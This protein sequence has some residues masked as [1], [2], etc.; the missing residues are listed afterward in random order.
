MRLSKQGDGRW[1]GEVPGL[2]EVAAYGAH[3]REALRLT[4]QLARRVCSERFE[5]GETVPED[6]RFLLVD[7]RIAFLCGLTK[8]GRRSCRKV[9]PPAPH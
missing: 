5:R 7:M 6:L 1:R 2:P 9:G 8:D 4:S 3:R